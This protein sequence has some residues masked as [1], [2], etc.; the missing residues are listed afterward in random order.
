MPCDN[1][2]DLP[3]FSIF[4]YSTG[5]ERSYNKDKKSEMPGI[6]SS[7]SKIFAKT[8]L[9]MVNVGQSQQSDEKLHFAPEASIVNYYNTKSLMGG[10]RDELEIALDKPVVSLS[11]GLS[12]VFLLGGKSKDE[13]PVLPILIRAG[14]VMC[15]GGDSRLNYHSMARV[16]PHTVSLPNV[17]PSLCPV[18]NQKVTLD[19]IGSGNENN[20]KGSSPVGV[21]DNDLAALDEYLS[22]HRININVRQ[23]Y[24]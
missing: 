20:V 17:E 2:L 23:V 5:T 24:P 9:A 4:R 12:A 16:L 13:H 7:L 19:T 14:D 11:V 6:M 3:F 1:C 21:S 10:H 18:G 8:S 15:L 22:E